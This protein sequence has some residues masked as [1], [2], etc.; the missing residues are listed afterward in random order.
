MPCL[1]T[2]CNKPMEDC[3]FTVCINCYLEMTDEEV[4]K[5]MFLGG[6]FYGGELNEL[7]KTPKVDS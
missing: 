4:K 1:C 5:N 3:E 7:Q 2:R 6:R